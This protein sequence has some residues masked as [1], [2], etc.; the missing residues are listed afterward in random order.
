[1]SVERVRVKQRYEGLF[2]QISAILFRHDPMDISGEDNT[3]EYEPEV[4]TILPRLEKVSSE[5]EA[6]AVIHQE[7]GRWFGE[8]LA[9]S[10]S[11]YKDAAAEIW[12]AWLS[13]KEAQS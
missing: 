7:F 4:G 9:G 12:S 3:D 2:D 1:M 5:E 13:Y 6:L 11:R 10:K 8:D